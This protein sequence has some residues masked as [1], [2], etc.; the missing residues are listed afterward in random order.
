MSLNQFIL[1]TTPETTTRDEYNALAE[2]LKSRVYVVGAQES[3]IGLSSGVEQVR[4]REIAVGHILDGV[5]SGLFYLQ[6]PVNRE[7]GGLPVI[8]LHGQRGRTSRLTFLASPA[9]A[10]KPEVGQLEVIRKR[11]D[12]ESVCFNL[13]LS[14]SESERFDHDILRRDLSVNEIIM[15]HHYKTFE[16]REDVQEADAKVEAVYN[17]VVAEDSWAEQ[18][19]VRRVYGVPGNHFAVRRFERTLG[20]G[21]MTRLLDDHLMMREYHDW[22]C[23]KVKAGVELEY[24]E[25]LNGLRS[26][27]RQVISQ[28][29]LEASVLGKPFHWVVHVDN[30]WRSMYFF[31]L[32]FDLAFLTLELDQLVLFN[33]SSMLVEKNRH[34]VADAVIE[35]NYPGEGVLGAYLSD[36]PPTLIYRGK[37]VDGKP[38]FDLGDLGLPIWY[39]FDGRDVDGEVCDLLLKTTVSDN[40][41]GSTTTNRWIRFDPAQDKPVRAARIV[42]STHDGDG[43]RKNKFHWVEF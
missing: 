1:I 13:P 40:Y 37:I 43:N 25:V 2:E 16:V 21:V 20:A 7:P 3:L 42:L 23:D 12:D 5:F 29:S 22:L 9:L 34:G 17:Q 35:V 33:N 30:A 39:S 6:D 8:C 14:G 15:N 28:I 31:G 41:G 24:Q 32:R 11:P 26:T 18:K 4:L 38:V 27:L 19:L 36:E 10:Y